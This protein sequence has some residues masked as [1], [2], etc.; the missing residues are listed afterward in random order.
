MNRIVGRML[1][2]LALFCGVMLPAKETVARLNY[3]I[4]VPDSP[5][6]IETMAARELAAYLEK[7]YSEKIRL[8]GSDDPILFSVGFAPEAR[9]FDKGKDAFTESGFGVFCRKRTV[10]LTGLDDPNVRPG[11]GCEEGT[12]LS[13]YYFLR[14]YTGLKIYAPDPVHGEKVG[15]NPELKLPPEDKPVFSFSLRGIGTHFADV[16]VPQMA[17]Y[18]RKQLC[19]K[20]YWTSVN[21]FYVVLNRW[22]KRFK[23]QP[24][25]LGLHLGKRQCISYPYHLPCLTN[26]KVKEVIVN[27]ILERIRK[28]KVGECAVLRIFC[29]APFSRCECP[30]CARFTSNNDYLYGFILSVWESVKK[31]YPKTRLTLQEKGASHNSPPSAG[32]LKDVVVDISTGFPDKTD[33]RR[34]QPLFRK[35]QDRGALPTLRLYTRYPKWGRCPIINPHDIAANFRAIKGFALGQRQSDQGRRIPYAF[36]ALTN[37]V[38]VNCLLN[39]DADPDELI[40]DFCNFMYPGAAKEM[41]AFYD[42]ME[43]RQK[44]LGSGDNPYLKCYPFNAMD[45]PVA[46]L[47]AAA[48]VCTDPF[49]LNK[50][51]TA[52]NGFLE[53]TRQLH[54]ITA[55]REENVR[56]K[57]QL[58][59]EFQKRF[60]QPF[61][62]TDKETAFPLCPQNV[63]CAPMQDST[64]YVR[65]ENDRLV[66]RLTA[67][68]EH[69]KLLRRTATKENPNNIW[70]DDSFEIMIAPEKQESPYLHFAINANGM[71]VA[72]RHIRQKNSQMGKLL[73]DWKPAAEIGS[74]RWTAEFSVPLTLLKEICPDGKGRIGI[75]RTRVL[76]HP[77]PAMTGYYSASSGLDAAAE[78]PAHHKVSR[79]HPFI[80]R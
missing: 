79:Y 61:L 34:A 66:F 46:L 65:V 22:G 44:D 12:L 26:P 14:R 20:F 76:S 50:L 74:D 38:H 70:Q 43:K 77:N 27:D 24:E 17:L 18:S 8:N 2:G 15:R 56:K 23:D 28:R 73:G 54:A 47:D 59:A 41:I 53:E 57:K 48:K 45:V 62:F 75:F 16:S 3:R 31:H 49:W 72:F 29:D 32:N 13:V 39:A 80:L 52:F 69:T 10:L 42:W 71:I 11:F 1:T 5:A 58:Q 25:M 7:T 68:E 9:E 40:R 4:C 21:I 19:H 35:W 30:N 78:A 64:I 67:M 36:M 33:Y 51:R 37:Y 60:S 6:A 63:P 55:Y